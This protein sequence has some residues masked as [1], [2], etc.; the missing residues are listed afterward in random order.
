M[1]NFFLYSW[2]VL[3]GLV[4]IMNV[5]YE[6]AAFNKPERWSFY[7][8]HAIVITTLHCIASGMIIYQMLNNGRWCL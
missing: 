1:N 7:Q 3:T 6:I 4:V 8:L 5:L 2:Y